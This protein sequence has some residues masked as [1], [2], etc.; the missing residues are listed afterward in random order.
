MN[1]IDVAALLILVV[2]HF[3]GGIAAFGSSLMAV[4]FLLLLYGPEELAPILFVIVVVGLMQSTFLVWKNWRHTDVKAC[5]LLLAGAAC[6]IPLGME[7]VHVLPEAGVMILLGTLTFLAGAVNLLRAGT[8]T[9]LPW[10]VTGAVALVSGVIHGAFASGGTILVAYTQRLIPD[11]DRFRATLSMFWTLLNSGFVV[12]L[13]LRTD[14]TATLWMQTGTAC[15]AVLAV[16]FSANRVAK[17]MNRTVFQRLISLLL[18][19]SG[20]II[21]I[22]QLGTSLTP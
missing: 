15:A 9:S 6:G 12:A 18:V 19:V 2:T 13:F 20:L 16:S 3:I 8:A 11:R 10:P 14:V 17:R 5:A 21:L 7:L 22:R 1:A 4:P